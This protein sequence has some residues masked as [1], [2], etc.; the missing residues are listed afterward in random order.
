MK[1][2]KAV[3]K[4]IYNHVTGALDPAEEINSPNVSKT[5]GFG[6]GTRAQE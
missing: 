3:A 6:G 2:G 4:P 1:E 5:W